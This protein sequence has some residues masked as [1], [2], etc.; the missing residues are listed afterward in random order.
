M[1]LI[2]G[3]PPIVLELHQQG[4]LERAFNDALF[5]ALLFRSEALAEEWPQNTGDELVMTR[6]GLLPPITGPIVPGT[7]P[8]PQNVPFEQ[9]VAKLSQFAGT[10]DTHMPSSATANANMLMRNIQQLGLQAGQSVDR[11]ARNNLFLAYLQ[12]N[13]NIIDAVLIGAVQLHVASLN[14]FTE[15]TAPGV[16]A[17]PQPVSATNPLPATLGVGVAAVSVSI[18][19]ASPDNPALPLG[20]G[21][22]TLAAALGAGF[23]ARSPLKSAYAT[24][25]VRPSGGDSVDNISAADT[26]VLQQAIN[27]VAILRQNNVQPHEDGF[28]H[29][30][31]SPTA[32]AQVFADP[33]FQ[34]LN[35]SLPEHVIYKEG[36]I[37][38]ISGVMFFMNQQ[39]PDATNVSAPGAVLPSTGLLAKHGPEVGADVINKDGVAIGRTILT[40]KGALYERY[41]DESA[42]MSEAGVTGKIG[43]FSVVN[44]GLQILT[45]RIR[46]IMRAPLD[47]LQ[48]SVASS[49]SLST[50]FPVPSDITASSSPA[51]FKRAVVLEFAAG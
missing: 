40:G 18:I 27:A 32:N 21:V 34:R 20:P 35:Q 7:D 33:V 4:L 39:A 42:Y 15:A 16:I 13:T 12:G 3:I 24:R 51:K 49:W 28:Y 5:P 22:V 37:G 14:G 48:Q 9:W 1:S 43:E 44:N 29:A 36:F 45:E 25:V 10:I 50:A 26:F 41:L 30:H 19:A 46:F 17:R 8:V 11:L 23:A 38:T 6:A 47:R 2:L 31:I